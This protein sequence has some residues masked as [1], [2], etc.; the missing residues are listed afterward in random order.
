ML[1][2]LSDAVRKEG[3]SEANST[4]RKRSFFESVKME[5]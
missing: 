4:I 5:H 2:K 1:P 3:G